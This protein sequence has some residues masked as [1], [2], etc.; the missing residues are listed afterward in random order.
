MLQSL[1]GNIAKGQKDDL[2]WG[3]KADKKHFAMLSKKL[4]TVIMGSSTFVAMGKKAL[5]NRKN[6]V[7]T[8]DPQKYNKLQSESLE[9]F[10]GTPLALVQ[11]LEKQGVKKAALIGGSKIN[12]SFFDAGLIDDIFI[13]IAP[14]IFTKGIGLLDETSDLDIDLKL[15]KINKLDANT[16]SLHYIVKKNQ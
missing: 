16:L 1:N 12:T 5:P 7:L 9:F 14:I 13:I 15:K 11:S 10:K 3:G 8:R 6:I 4:G 2:A